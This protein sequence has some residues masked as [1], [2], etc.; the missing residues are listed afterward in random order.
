MQAMEK[1]ANKELDA[2]TEKLFADMASKESEAKQ[3]KLGIDS[4]K[5][6]AERVKRGQQEVLKVLQAIGPNLVA[7]AEE[8][9]RNRPRRDDDS[10]PPPEMVAQIG[11]LGSGG[12]ASHYANL[13]ENQLS[14]LQDR[15]EQKLNEL[16][17]S[18]K[19]SRAQ[20]AHHDMQKRPSQVV[21]ATWSRKSHPNRT[22]W[23]RR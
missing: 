3:V 6:K 9:A 7:Q 1:P 15:V 10:T 14:A 17:A 5:E 2:A 4:L 22:N 18:V 11:S 21:A 8:D 19:A 16:T 12:L 13:G 20:H 23:F